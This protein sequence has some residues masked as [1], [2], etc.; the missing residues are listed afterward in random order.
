[1][2]K[3]NNEN[4][5]NK[6][7][8]SD[9]NKQDNLKTMNEIKEKLKANPELYSQYINN[10]PTYLEDFIKYCSNSKYDFTSRFNAFLNYCKIKKS[11]EKSVILKTSLVDFKKE[12]SADELKGGNEANKSAFSYSSEILTSYASE[13][14]KTVE[15]IIV[16]EKSS[17]SVIIDLVNFIDKSNFNG[18]L[19]EEHLGGSLS[20]LKNLGILLI[21][22]DMSTI[23]SLKDFF[24]KKLLLEP[25]TNYLI[26]SVILHKAPLI[27]L[28]SIQKFEG[29]Q[30]IVF[31]N[32]KLHLAEFWDKTSLVISKINDL[33]FVEFERVYSYLYQMQEVSSILKKVNFIFL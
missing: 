9:E 20:K 15:D 21:L 11:D 29:K 31:S 14:V 28:V 5:N 30:D 1:M 26:K 32:M 22:A 6:N 12:L 24:Q 8:Q 4:Q 17:S 33:T 7:E 13:N 25:K 19:D 2:E 27:S 16:L 3:S 18:P 10:R 23:M